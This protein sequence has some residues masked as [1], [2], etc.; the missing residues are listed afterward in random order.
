MLV[1]VWPLLYQRALTRPALGP[2]LSRIKF[3]EE[4]KRLLFKYAEAARRLIESRFALSCP[5]QAGFVIRVGRSSALWPISW[6]SAALCGGRR[7][8]PRGSTGAVRDALMPECQ[9]GG[10]G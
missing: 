4:A 3:R 7:P 8:A 1:C 5:Q 6:S 10:R 2:R 9:C